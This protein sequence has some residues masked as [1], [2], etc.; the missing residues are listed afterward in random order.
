MFTTKTRVT[1]STTGPDGRLTLVSIVNMMQDCSQ[2]WLESEPLVKDYF[3]NNGLSLVISSRQIDV[4][5]YPSYGEELE[6][7][8]SVYECNK[9]FGSRNTCLKGQK[10]GRLYAKSWS[11]GVFIDL[12]T[13][14]PA[15]LSERA[16]TSLTYDPKLAMN[17]LDKRISLPLSSSREYA[18]IAVQRSDIDFNRHVNNAQYIRMAYN[19]LAPEQ[20]INRMRVEYKMPSRLGDI[21]VPHVYQEENSPTLV[22]LANTEAKPYAYVEF[23]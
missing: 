22:V 8:T 6:V 19:C 18:P 2:L 23:S 4:I 10:N 13:G 15:R 1:A 21:I 12:E 16:L 14:K 11:I 3:L 9:Y 20:C 17:Y 7:V 5:N